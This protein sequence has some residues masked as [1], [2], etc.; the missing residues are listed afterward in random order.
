MKLQ[1]KWIGTFFVLTGILLTNLN[2][3][4]SNI[5]FHG[6]GVVL[7]TFHGYFNKDNAILT[8]FGCQVPIFFFGIFN[9]FF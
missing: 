2:I 4:P 6:F 9:C 8:N 5:F 3:Y 7:W 1:L